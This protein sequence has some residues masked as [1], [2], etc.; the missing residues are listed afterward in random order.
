[1]FDRKVH[2]LDAKGN[3][4]RVT[5]YTEIVALGYPNCLV[6][7]GKFYDV[8]GDPYPE[9]LLPMVLNKQQ[10]EKWGVKAPNEKQTDQVTAAD[11][12]TIKRR[13]GRPP[14]KKEEVGSD[15]LV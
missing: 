4:Q 10:M 15:D 6:R 14:T 9:H 12:E 5:A 13:P 11:A 8:N 2:H 3:I 1:M 7:G